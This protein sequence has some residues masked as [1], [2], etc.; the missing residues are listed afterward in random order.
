[1]EV[2]GPVAATAG[3]AVKLLEFSYRVQN[4]SHQA[5]DYLNLAALVQCDLN[6]AIRLRNDYSSSLDAPALSRVDTVIHSTKDALTAVA[7]LV[8]DARVEMKE[9]GR[10]G[11]GNKLAWAL[12][13]SHEMGTKQ[14]YL[15]G[16]QQS[17]LSVIAELKGWEGRERERGVGTTNAAAPPAYDEE[18]RGRWMAALTSKHSVVRRHRGATTPA[19]EQQQFPPTFPP[20]PPSSYHSQTPTS[21]PQSRTPPSSYFPAQPFPPPPDRY[22]QPPSPTSSYYSTRSHLQPPS[23]SIPEGHPY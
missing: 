2:I 23:P 1:M 10:V 17:L 14:V 8:E 13:D 4:T 3:A 19:R 11:M 15:Q 12:R 5:Q 9:K 18:E 20:T 6:E 22:R 21:D 7:A 16:C